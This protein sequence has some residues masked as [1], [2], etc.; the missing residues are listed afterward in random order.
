[1]ERKEFFLVNLKEARI[2]AKKTQKEIAKFLEMGERHYQYIEYGTVEPTLKK[3][4]LIADYLGVSIDYL[5]G[6]E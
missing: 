2:K 6:R 4:C 3:V 1:M 5:V